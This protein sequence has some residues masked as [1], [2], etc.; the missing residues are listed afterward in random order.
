MGLLGSNKC[1][2]IELVHLAKTRSMKHN[3]EAFLRHSIS[4]V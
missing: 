1:Q 3:Q 2:G 4:E